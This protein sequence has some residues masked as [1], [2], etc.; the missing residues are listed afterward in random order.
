MKRIIYF[1]AC[2]I[3]L[4]ASFIIG[5][6]DKDELE[7]T[8]GYLHL[9]VL[10]QANNNPVANAKV[11]LND[12]LYGQTDE[13]GKYA[14]DSMSTGNYILTCTA[15]NFLDTSL[16]I[17]IRG[18]QITQVNL[19]MIA[20][21]FGKVFGEFQDLILFNQNAVDNPKL[22]T[23]D[24]EQVYDGVT[25][26]TIDKFGFHHD[27]PERKVISDDTILTVSDGY[28]QYYFKIQS[29]TYLLTGSCDGY[30]DTS[31]EIKVLPGSSNYVNFFLRKK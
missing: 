9:T 26:A 16:T 22:K 18:G 30:A 29:G 3:F 21:T 11:I 23:W 1:A 12:N 7:P 25:G 28:G 24:E 20:D 17:T 31:R 10:S 4:I 14:N 2:F 15:I 8:K 19:A 13:T 27:V 5:C 6:K